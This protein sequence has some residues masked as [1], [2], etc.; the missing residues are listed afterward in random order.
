[1]AVIAANG[2]EDIGPLP[3]EGARLTLRPF[4]LA[5]APAI[6]RLLGD[7][8]VVRYAGEIP[9]PYGLADANEFIGLTHR[10]FIHG[11]DSIFAAVRAD[12]GALVGCIAL[13]AATGAAIARLGYWF[14]RDH[15]GR[16]YATEAIALIL[17]Y[18]F[19]IRAY[20]RIE[21]DVHID[22]IASWRALERVGLRFEGIA[23][24]DF[25]ARGY[26]APARRYA[27]DRAQWEMRS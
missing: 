26:V 1:M 8:E 7:F 2:L 25:A 12:D 19:G 6:V 24:L 4:T 3:I 16:G 23:E 17:G 14:G 11:R 10:H 20:P 22:N 18:G 27:L 5:D 15:W 13:Q 21:A 9:W